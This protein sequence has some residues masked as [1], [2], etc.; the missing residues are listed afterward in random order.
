[1]T[2]PEPSTGSR[3]ENGGAG[4]REKTLQSQKLEALGQ[5]TGGVAHDFNNILTIILGHA[6][7][8]PS[9]DGASPEAAESVREII[10]GAQR[11]ALLQAALHKRIA[12]R[13]AGQ[14]VL[15]G[16]GRIL[17]VLLRGPDA[18]W[19]SASPILVHRGALA[20]PSPFP[21]GLSNPDDDLAAPNS[22]F[23]KLREAL[24]LLGEPARPGAFVV[25]LGASP[26]G[27]THVLRQLGCQVTAVDR[28]PLAPGLM[29]D[30]RVA[31]AV[32][33]AFAWQPAHAVDGLVCDVIAAPERSCALLE[34]WCS[35]RWMRWFVVHLK[36]KGEPAWVTLTAAIAAAHAHGYACRAK[37]FFND[38]NEVTVLGLAGA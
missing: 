25:D 1:M 8:L 35:Q 37:H 12:R 21:A 29:A 3:T 7:L 22:A 27:W 13:H 33:D 2:G 10:E 6:S 32:G 19:V 36:F 11:A 9:I 31:F 26:G 23:R 16:P 30:P 34:K 38:K 17:Q 14:L 28:A 18:G 15:P 20:W 24:A 4:T 5:L